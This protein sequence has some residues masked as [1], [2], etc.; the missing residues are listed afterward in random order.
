MIIDEEKEAH[1]LA[2]RER[3]QAAKRA[4]ERSVYVRERETERIRAPVLGL[5]IAA[6]SG[7]IMGALGMLALLASWV[8]R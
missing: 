7:A 8:S 2:A 1:L 6:F 3:Y 4:D 5:V